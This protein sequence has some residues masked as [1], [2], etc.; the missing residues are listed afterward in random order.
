VAPQPPYNPDLA[1][2]DFWLFPK[3]KTLKEGLK[4]CVAVNGDLKNK[5]T[6][7]KRNKFLSFL[8]SL[9]FYIVRNLFH[10]TG[11][12]TYQSPLTV[13]WKFNPRLKK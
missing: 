5:C 6:M 2:S 4:K 13:P 9:L 7:C 11:D 1:P 12:L 8:N 10:T 3:L